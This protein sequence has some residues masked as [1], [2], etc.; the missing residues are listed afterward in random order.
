MSTDSE[1]YG[2]YY[3]TESSYNGRGSSNSGGGDANDRRIAQIEKAFGSSGQ[4]R[5]DLS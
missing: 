1:S 2:L 5:N 4:V 3:E